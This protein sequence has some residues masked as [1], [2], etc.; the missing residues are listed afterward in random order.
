M[1]VSVE[2]ETLPGWCCST[3]T[4]RSFEELPPQAQ[5]YVR[6]VEDFLQ[7]PGGFR[8]ALVLACRLQSGAPAKAACPFCFQ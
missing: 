1:R 6:F 8:R 4:A 5:D 7:V 3:E 2:Y